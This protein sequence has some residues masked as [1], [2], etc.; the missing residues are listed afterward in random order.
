[1]SLAAGRIVLLVDDL[2]RSDRLEVD[3]ALLSEGACMPV[4]K[5]MKS[6]PYRRLVLESLAARGIEP[7]AIEK[8][9]NGV[10][11]VKVAD[12]DG[13]TIAFAEPPDAA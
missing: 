12:P 9:S 11:R 2:A 7:D 10:R 1:V 6:R 13:S 5:P 3:D 4:G 8:H